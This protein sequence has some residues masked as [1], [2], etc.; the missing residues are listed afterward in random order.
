M[1]LIN[2]E[3]KQKNSI[4]ECIV[5]QREGEQT[6][7]KVSLY[8]SSLSI[9]D[10]VASRS[11]FRIFSATEDSSRTFWNTFCEKELELNSWNPT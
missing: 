2:I 3:I 9:S 10:D 8:P 6:E 1:D 11:I 7:G 5:G 4:D